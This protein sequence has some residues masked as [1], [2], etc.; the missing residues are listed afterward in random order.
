MRFALNRFQLR[1]QHRQM[2]PDDLPHP[3]Q[4]YSQVIV[5]ED[6]SEPGNCP[7]VNLRMRRLQSIADSLGGFGKRLK[8]AQDCILDEF[9]V[10][11]N[12][13]AAPAIALYPVDAIQNMVNVR[14]VVGNKGLA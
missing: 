13:L 3:H 8:V 11:K 10:G 12:L 9:L 5:D 7:P 14:L 4:V 6:I 2:Y 1:T